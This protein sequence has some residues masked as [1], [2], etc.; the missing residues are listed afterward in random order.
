MALGQGL[1]LQEW[2]TL[3]ISHWLSFLSV[4]PVGYL[5]CIIVYVNIHSYWF[6]YIQEQK[7]QN[8]I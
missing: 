4:L 3:S 5:R 8:L 6:V 2:R 1:S 7:I